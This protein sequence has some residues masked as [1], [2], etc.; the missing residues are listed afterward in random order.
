MRFLIKTLVLCCLF[1]PA[2]AKAPE[3][4][5]RPLPRG[6]AE[7]LETPGAE[8]TPQWAEIRPEAR[9]TVFEA[10]LVAQ[11]VRKM[12]GLE[13]VERKQ[14]LDFMEPIRAF[15]AASP[16][17]VAQALRPARRTD[18]VV[19]KAMAQ[20]QREE[21]GSVCGDPKLQGDYVGY[22]PGGGSA[23][24]ITEGVKVRAVN[25]VP[26]T[27][28][29]LVDCTTAKS[30]KNWVNNVL[31][32]TVGS[33]GGGVAQIRV[34]AHYACRTRNHQP[35]AKVSEHGRGKAIDISG[36]I[37]RDGS[38]ISV[39]DG[40]DTSRDGDVLRRLHGRACGIFGTVLG[41]ESDRFHQDHFHFDTARHG[42]GPYCR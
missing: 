40:W 25:G 38:E 19:Q 33:R 31:K 22:V 13:P 6:A 34:A 2:S 41:P 29:A 35:G 36:I 15:A 16:Q 37:L 27:Q 12:S 42:N 17:A 5:L 10:V 28:A 26:L 20:R 32:P 30:L 21:R 3:T 11:L 24:G 14:P 39:L 8:A 7:V 4:S 1:S 18:A 9:P 23:C